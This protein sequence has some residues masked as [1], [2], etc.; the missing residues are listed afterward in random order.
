MPIFGANL[1]VIGDKTQGV[2]D[3]TLFGDVHVL[4]EHFHSKGDVYPKLVNPVQLQKDA[5]IWAAIPSTKTEIIPVDTIGD[6]FDIH[7]VSASNISA[8][9]D[10]II[11]LYSGLAG[12]EVEIGSVD[13]V[14]NAVQSQEG[15]QPNQTIVVP[16]GTR[17]SAGMSSGNNA[18]D[19]L[20]VKVRY[21]PY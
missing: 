7:F 20:S 12:F 16:A 9:G 18:Q 11:C 15:A 8:N 17:I 4:E 13:V 6:A 10:Y 1:N 14:R 19:T 2:N 5:G 3:H 21:H